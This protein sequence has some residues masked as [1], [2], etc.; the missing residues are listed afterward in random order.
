MHYG[1]LKMQRGVRRYQNK[2]G[3]WTELGKERRRAGNAGSTRRIA[4]ESV[5]LMKRRIKSEAKVD[6]MLTKYNKHNS[7]YEKL[8]AKAE[9]RIRR[10][11]WGNIGR[12]QLVKAYK[13][14]AKADSLIKKINKEQM[15]ISDIDLR[16]VD[17]GKKYVE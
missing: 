15:K 16:L 7:K 13:H 5:N 9:K 2:D 4:K 10:I 11:D 12:N 1:T 6:K 3:T 17:L 8:S 14:K